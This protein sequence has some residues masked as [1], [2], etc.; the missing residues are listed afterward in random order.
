MVRTSSIFGQMLRLIDRGDFS[1]VVRT[2]GGN[3]YTKGF[4]A[5]HHFTAMLFCQLA[6]AKSLRE[7]CDGLRCTVGKLVHLGVHKAPKRTT[8]AYAN[9]HRPAAVYRDLFY[10]LVRRLDGQLGQRKRKFRFRNKLLSLDSSTITL[11]LGLFPW[12]DYTRTKGGVK[13]HML[14]DHDGYWPSYVLLTDAKCADITVA[15]TLVLPKGSVVVLDRGYVDYALWG[16]WTRDDGVFFVTRMKV[17]TPYQVVERRTIADGSKGHILR[18][19]VV[20][21]TST[22][23]REHCPYRLRRIVVWD[24]KNQREFV[25]LTNHE[26]FSAATIAEIYR[27]RWEIEL[28][29][30]ALK[31]NLKIKT[32]VGT[33]RN[34]LE[35]QIWTA[36]IAMLLLKHLQFV[37]QRGWSLS[38]L[39]ALLRMNLFVY[40]D[41]HQWLED[42]FETPPAAPDSPQCTL[43]GFDFG[44]LERAATARA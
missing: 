23:A 17:G 32:F 42:P 1:R 3:R 12:A 35:V 2:H 14:L 43:P 41:L 7:I 8:L 37:T 39:V 24:H 19:E 9:Q 34:A 25:F 28:F 22:T 15:R 29:F 4:T 10:A 33:S 6:Q 21:L 20:R 36:L 5:W 18:D 11:C 44:Q 16:R 31:Q 13:L 27:D 30:K 40:K 38:N 26:T